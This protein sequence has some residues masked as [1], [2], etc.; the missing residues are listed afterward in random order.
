[1]TTKTKIILILV[2]GVLVAIAAMVAFQ[3]GEI[4]KDAVVVTNTF[5]P[6]RGGDK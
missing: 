4:Y 2:L 1:M 6:R 3:R 5:Q